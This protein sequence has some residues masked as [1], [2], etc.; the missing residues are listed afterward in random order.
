M[1]RGLSSPQH[2]PKK[3]GLQSFSEPSNV[4]GLLRTGKSALRSSRHDSV[5]L[6]RSLCLDLIHLQS[7]PICHS[8]RCGIN[9]QAA[10]WLLGELDVII[11]Y[12]L[13]LAIG[14]LDKRGKLVS[15]YRPSFLRHAKSSDR[16]AKPHLW[17]ESLAEDSHR[18]LIANPIGH[19]ASRS[20]NPS[21]QYADHC[22]RYE[23]AHD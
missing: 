9:P 11:R 3:G 13:K 2:C 18:K 21:S 22:V 16:S 5:A 8:R 14:L 15:I 20:S 1:E 7:H 12:R 17:N 6:L 10:V 23:M 19:A 4:P